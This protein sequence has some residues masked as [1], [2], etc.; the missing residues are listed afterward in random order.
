M[1]IF[2]L[3]C[4]IV[5]KRVGLCKLRKWT[6]GNVAWK[7][8]CSSIITTLFFRVGDGFCCCWKLIS[9]FV[10]QRLDDSTCHEW[11]CCVE[12]NTYF[13]I[14]SAKSYWDSLRGD[15]FFSTT[16]VLVT[17]FCNRPRVWGHN[18][19]WN[20]SLSFNLAYGKAVFDWRQPFQTSSGCHHQTSKCQNAIG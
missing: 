17:L 1:S 13:L 11:K 5:S 20:Q 3:N 10:N 16:V 15:T 6:T 8:I 18:W 7:I 9:P 19:G 4:F 2:T 12:K 14:A